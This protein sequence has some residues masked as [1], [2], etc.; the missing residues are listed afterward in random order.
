MRFPRNI[1]TVFA[2]GEIFVFFVFFIN[3]SEAFQQAT[4]QHVD[5]SAANTRRAVLQLICFE[6]F[7]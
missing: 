1:I 4:K 7:V 3:K 5:N 6:L 2:S